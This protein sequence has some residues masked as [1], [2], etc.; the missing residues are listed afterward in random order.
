VTKK[1]YVITSGEYSDYGIEAV[2]T[3]EELAK[4]WIGEDTHKSGYCKYNIEEYDLDSLAHR[5]VPAHSRIE[6]EIGSG[7]V[8]FIEKQFYP[9]STDKYGVY[10]ELG[11][12]YVSLKCDTITVYLDHEY[13]YDRMTKI[14]S[15]V[16]T[17][18]LYY[19]DD[20][21]KHIIDNGKP[22]KFLNWFTLNQRNLLHVI[23]LDNPEYR[24]DSG[25]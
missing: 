13:T 22:S 20:I 6:M 25:V 11:T 23:E 7:K 3:T 21:L 24:K 9:A 19:K 17:Q 10:G 2:F 1:I 14:A 8:L 4:Q 15:E 18:F 16:R 12:V 5:R